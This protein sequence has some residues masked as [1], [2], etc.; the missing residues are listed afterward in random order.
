MPSSDAT[1][2]VILDEFS[3]A[4]RVINAFGVRSPR[5]DPLGELQRSPRTPSRNRGR[6]S[7]SKGDGR[8][9]ERIGKG[10]ERER[11]GE[12]KG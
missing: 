5:P 2:S 11:K 8:G 6:G 4:Q 1:L 3:T 7:T 12:G 9:E 10:K